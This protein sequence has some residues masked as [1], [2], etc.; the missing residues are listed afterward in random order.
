MRSRESEIDGIGWFSPAEILEMDTF[1]NV[2]ESVK[3]AV[4]YMEGL[5]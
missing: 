5:E 2:R 3:K 1:E 4:R